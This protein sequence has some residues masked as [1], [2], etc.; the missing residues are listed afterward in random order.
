MGETYQWNLFFLL[1]FAPIYVH[2]PAP[3]LKLLS[4]SALVML[5]RLYTNQWNRCEETENCFNLAR[6]KEE[7]RFNLSRYSILFCSEG[8]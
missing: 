3:V 4:V 8:L 6:A 2:K 7:R 5:Y 1:N